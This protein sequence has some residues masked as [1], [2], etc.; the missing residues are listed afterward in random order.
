[1]TFGA[2]TSAAQT[3]SPSVGDF[4]G[5]WVVTDV[6]DYSDI[7]GGIPEAKRILGKTMTITP[8]RLRS[9]R[10]P[11]YRVQALQLSTW[12]QRQS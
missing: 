4:V 9:T 12:I 3:K 11:A 8:S 1:M 10:K 2:G 7:S 6:V 5:K